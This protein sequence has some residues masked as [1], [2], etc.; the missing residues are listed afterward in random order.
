LKHRVLLSQTERERERETGDSK[1]I[2]RIYLS[3]GSV[4]AN[5]VNPT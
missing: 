3:G 2:F 1:V 4:R 5:V